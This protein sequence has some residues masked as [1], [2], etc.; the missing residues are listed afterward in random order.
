MYVGY[1]CTSCDYP[2]Q[3]RILRDK[4]C[5]CGLGFFEIEQNCVSNLFDVKL[6]TYIT[7]G[8]NSPEITLTF[9]YLLSVSP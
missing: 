6:K 2:T 5:M 1:E 9:N 3:H 4:Y 7:G 8:M